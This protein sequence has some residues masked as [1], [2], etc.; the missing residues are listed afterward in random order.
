MSAWECDRA[1]RKLRKEGA[2]SVDESEI[3]RAVTELRLKVDNSKKQT[4]KARRLAQR[5]T[6]HEK[7]V[8]PAAP[9]PKRSEV[10]KRADPPTDLV[11][12][13]I[14]GFGDLA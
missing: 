11:D 1:R 6:E 14:D 12:G 4:K 5:R 13:D 10:A 3:H 7:A 2:A 9:I 8:S